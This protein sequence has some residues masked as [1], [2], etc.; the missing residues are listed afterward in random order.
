M[1]GAFSGAMPVELFNVHFE[2]SSSKQGGCFFA[3]SSV[4]CVACTFRK[5]QTELG[6]G[7][8]LALAIEYSHF[9]AAKAGTALGVRKD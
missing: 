9:S 6:G 1:G 8:A 2:D 4:H 3:L 7:F 5:A